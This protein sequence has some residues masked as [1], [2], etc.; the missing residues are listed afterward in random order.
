[1]STPG[2]GRRRAANPES[3]QYPEQPGVDPRI[4]RTLEVRDQIGRAHV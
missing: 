3:T 2:T 1:M 4:H